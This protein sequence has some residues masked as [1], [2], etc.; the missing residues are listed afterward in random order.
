MVL[1]GSNLDEFK[2]VTSDLS[3]I[4]HTI[5]NETQAIILLSSLLE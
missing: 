4:D 3:F 1:G 5:E 2:K